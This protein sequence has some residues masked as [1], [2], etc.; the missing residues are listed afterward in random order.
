MLGDTARPRLVPGR[1]ARTPGIET[2][3]AAGSDSGGPVLLCPR[4][5]LAERSLVGDVPGLRLEQRF[6][7][8]DDGVGDVYLVFDSMSGSST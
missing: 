4:S 5:F 6:L 8:A 2:H 1:R 3:R 7:A